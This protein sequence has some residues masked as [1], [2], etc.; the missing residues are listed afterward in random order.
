MKKFIII[1][2]L[3][4]SLFLLNAA[5]EQQVVNHSYNHTT[6]T[7]NNEINSLL[8][9]EETENTF[10]HTV[11]LLAADVDIVINSM[12]TAMYDTEGNHIGT[13]TNKDYSRVRLANSFVMR[14]LFGFTI[15]TDLVV[16]NNGIKSVVEHLS[17]D[18]VGSGSRTM[19]ESISP[20][21]YESYKVLVDNFRDSYMENLPFKQEKM[22]IISHSSLDNQLTPFI[23]WKKAKGI[24]I[25]VVH[26]TSI[27]PN[28]SS[29]QIRAYIQN[30]YSN[31]ELKPDYIL[32]IGDV[33]GN[34]AIPTFYTGTANDATDLPYGM[35]DDDDYLPEILVGR[36][37]IDSQ[38]N[39]ATII[40]KTIYY[41]KNPNME[42]TEWMTSALAA[43][44]NYATSTP[45]PITP[46]LMSRW[47]A[48]LWAGSGYTRV[49]TVFWWM[50]MGGYGTSQITQSLNRG[51]QYVNYRGWGDANGW[52]YPKFYISD[53]NQTQ[54]GGKLPIVTS[55]VC[56]T[57]DF[58]NPNV[59]PSFGEHWM[60]MGTPNTPNGAVAFLGPTDLYTSTEYNN[61]LSSGFH[62]GVQR[63]GIRIFSSALLRGKME[64]YKNYPNNLGPG[65]WVEHYFKVYN[66]LS[67]PSLQMWRLIPSQM[68]LNLP[69]S[70]AKGTN[71]LSFETPGLEGGYVTVTQDN[72][73]FRTFR[74]D[75]DNVFIPL[76][77][78]LE[79]EILVTVTAK[80]YLPKQRNIE[81]IPSDNISVL[82]YNYD[83][84]VVNAGSDIT[85]NVTLKNYSENAASDV[86][87]V[88]SSNAPQFA[89][90]TQDTANLG[91][92]A[93]GGTAVGSFAFSI[94]PATPRYTAIQFSITVTPTNSVSKIQTIVGGLNF[95]FDEPVVHSNNG[96]LDPGDTADISITITNSGEVGA[97]NLSAFVIPQTEAVIINNNSTIDFGNI[98]VGESATG[99]INVTALEDG[100]I[101]RKAYFQLNF[102]DD[103]GLEA[104]GYFFVTIGTVTNTA[105]TGPDAY[106]YFAYDSFDT[107]YDYAPVYEWIDID[108]ENEGPGTNWWLND[109]ATFTMDLP[110]TFRYYGRE[111]NEI[112]ICSNGWVTFIPTWL[113]NFRN[114]SI[115][116]A[117][118]PPGLIAP[119]W[120]DLK[121]TL[122][123]DYKVRIAYYY[124]EAN[125]RFIISWLDARNVANLSETGIEK[126]QMILEPRPGR[127]GDIIF[128]YHTIWN[129]NSNRNFSTTGIMNHDNTVGLQY[130]F[131]NRYPASATPL[132]AGLAIR[133]TTDAP[134]NFVSADSE[135]LP[136]NSNIVLRQ[137]YPNPF[138]PETTISFSIPTS[139][140]VKLDV[141]NVRGQYID[142]IVE[143]NLNAGNHEFVWNGK[144]R[145][146][147]QVGSGVYLYKLKTNTDTL[148]KRMLLLK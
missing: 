105:P 78:E 116:S 90:I 144:D 87:A 96:V 129:Q 74:I 9:I 66:I 132:Q 62:W 84:N 120:D 115:P 2:P 98:P 44:G 65:D 45:V 31:S 106:G 94:D 110:F 107:A 67:D 113:I 14:E 99:T 16:D 75:G 56:N 34:H 131:F 92:I 88:L 58:A 82:E 54:N 109:D 135:T 124:D 40:A 48:E 3:M 97:V 32:L 146:G 145:F 85:L 64:M 63:E 139:S 128:Q 26:K 83:G 33:T 35:M 24:D 114:W 53:L 38:L 27:A 118:N 18:V 100:Y 77:T 69:E 147:K 102:T 25:T 4:L 59:N 121:G 30:Y 7:L 15:N 76:S 12:T 101:G 52:H 137:N 6:I 22:L 71:Y 91:N 51:V 93:A 125:N 23:A 117:E 50:G 123:N 138:N 11:A 136:L 141:Y 70:L 130:A 122:D 13:D 119:M 127:N 29:S 55:F 49:D 133:F 111:Y 19:P 17:Y 46:V 81:I 89:V 148:T 37:S 36:F 140:Q 20:A 5:V 95:D 61:S 108:P 142:T 47:L 1:I 112:S 8:G 39:L 42:T 57:G 43:A 41:E 80:D 21:F 143:D 28:P 103:N 104:S 72:L 79:G 68:T 134:D 86:T 10:S 73:D 126:I 60:R